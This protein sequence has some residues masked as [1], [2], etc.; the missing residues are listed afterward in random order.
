MSKFNAKERKNIVNSLKGKEFDLLVIGG[1]ITGAGIALDAASRGLNVLVLEKKDFAFGTSSRSTKL[2]HGGLRYLEQ[3]EFGL[4]HEVGTERAIV[5]HNAM[6]IVIP[7]QMLLP[8]IQGGTLN[9]FMTSIGLTI[10]DFLAGVKKSERKKMLSREKT[11]EIEPVLDSPKLKSGALYYEY[12]TDDSRLT[13]EVMKKANEYGAQALNYAEVTDFIY[14]SKGKMIGLK[15]EDKIQ[16]LS[17]E[18]FGKYIV[19]ATGIWVDKLRE[20]DNSLKGK[21]LHITK[22]IHIVVPHEKLPINHA[23]YF[24]VGDGRM[25]FAIPRYDKVYIGTTDTDYKGDLDKPDITAADVEYLLKAVKHIAPSI[26]LTFDD[27]LSAWSGLRPLIHQEGKA[28]SELSRRDEIF[29]S[30]SGLISIAGGKLTGYRQMAKKVVDLV[31]KEMK[32]DYGND[33]GT[34]KTKNIKLAGGEFDFEY[35]PEKLMDFADMK[36]DL[37]KQTGISVEK[38]KRLFYRYGT[39][40]DKITE[41]AYKYYNE[42]KNTDLAW[43]KAEIEYSV[44]EEL[45]YTLTD[46]F[47][48]R[49]NLIYFFVDEIYPVL[50]T[51]A[52]FMQS[53]LDWSDEQKKAYLDEMKYELDKTKNWRTK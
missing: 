30:D 41:R 38:F 32:K 9:K 34:C 26:D 24:D 22:G 33:I 50:D 8:I 45:A 28:P 10:Y 39:N 46:F 51:A 52:D 5:H 31:R 20:K 25:V 47:M 53:L 14:D 17:F 42:G 49:T 4:V 43:L 7:S 40:I 36:Y 48:R 6:H 44:E 37:A 3:F 18:V 16:G 23:L 27:V 11:I 19:N 15:V 35:S 29:L 1:G 13:V 2:V 21:R 12:K